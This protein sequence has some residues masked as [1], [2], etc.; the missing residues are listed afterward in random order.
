MTPFK[1]AHPF[2]K[3]LSVHPDQLNDKV[4]APK[5]DETKA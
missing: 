2:S 5:I 3:P 1:G 4:I